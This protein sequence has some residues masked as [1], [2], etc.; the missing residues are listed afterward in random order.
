V[1]RH[2]DPSESCVRETTVLQ[3]HLKC[4]PEPRSLC[5]DAKRTAEPAI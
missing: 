2:R 5:A 3:A 1:S 4:G